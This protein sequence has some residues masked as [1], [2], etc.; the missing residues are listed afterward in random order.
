M[1]DHQ[2]TVAVF[3]AQD[4]VAPI[5]DFHAR[6]VAR[7]PRAPSSGGAPGASL[8]TPLVPGF[9]AYQSFAIMPHGSSAGRERAEEVEEF[10]LWARQLAAAMHIESIRLSWG[11][12]GTL[13][14]DEDDAPIIDTTASEALL[15]LSEDRSK[16]PHGFDVARLPRALRMTYETAGVAGPNMVAAAWKMVDA[17]RA[18]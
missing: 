1:G 6:V 13:V 9:N 18:G 8:V 2:H 3:I 12:Y 10:V 11:D 16:L 15:R 7:E 14:E 5:V 4:D 17:E